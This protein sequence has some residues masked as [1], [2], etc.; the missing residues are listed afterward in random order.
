MACPEDIMKQES[1][2]LT[3][4]QTSTTA[5]IQGNVLNLAYPEGTGP[6]DQ[7]YPAGTLILTEVTGSQ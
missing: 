6:A 5:Q 3:F 2:F 1:D 7:P 4:L